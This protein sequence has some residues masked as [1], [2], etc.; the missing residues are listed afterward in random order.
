MTTIANI[1]DSAGNTIPYQ[2]GPFPGL[3]IDMTLVANALQPFVK[4][5]F[6][7]NRLLPSDLKIVSDAAQTPATFTS[8]HDAITNGT[9]IFDAIGY[10]SIPAASRPTIVSENPLVGGRTKDLTAIAE[11]VAYLFFWLLTR[12]NI[13]DLTNPAGQQIPAFLRTILGYTGQP[14]QYIN[15]VAGFDLNKIE[16]KW[17]DKIN[18]PQLPSEVRN[19]FALGVAGYRAFAPFLYLNPK[20]GADATAIQVANVVKAFASTGFFWEIHPIYRST[21]LIQATGSLNKELGNLALAAFDATELANLATNRI[22][23][24]VPTADPRHN[25]WRSWTAATFASATTPIVI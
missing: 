14:S 13:P 3:D 5:G 11:G 24:A 18:M 6:E 20:A 16:H 4:R 7:R 19:R 2:V 15:R 9:P 10:F 23:F 1:Q 8:I 25:R 12:A 22:I 21:A 17:I